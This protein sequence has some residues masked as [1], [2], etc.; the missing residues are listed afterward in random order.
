MKEE[1]NMSCSICGLG[2]CRCKK[3]LNVTIKKN[4][5]ECV[6][7]LHNTGRTKFLPCVDCINGNA[8]KKD[9]HFNY[10]EWLKNEYFHEIKEIES[11][12][13]NYKVD[14]V[15]HPI[16][17]TSN[18]IETIEY[19]LDTVT[20]GESYCIGNVI[21]YISRYRYKHG[22]EDLKKAIWYINKTIEILE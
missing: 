19:I 22:K 17:Y 18:N 7:C 9:T 13:Q 5:A 21:K 15:N 6:S 20:D 3:G 12:V 16:H 10:N 14:N 11:D 8:Y 2:N 4:I 1:C